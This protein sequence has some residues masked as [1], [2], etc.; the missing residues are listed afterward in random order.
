MTSSCNAFLNCDECWL[1]SAPVWLG[2]MS[3][4]SSD[5]VVDGSLLL[6]SRV[7]SNVVSSSCAVGV[8][9]VSVAS[10]LVLK[11]SQLRFRMLLARSC[12][13]PR[14]RLGSGR[15]VNDV[16]NILASA[17]CRMGGRRVSLVVL[18]PARL[19]SVRSALVLRLEKFDHNTF[20]A[21]GPVAFC[22]CLRHLK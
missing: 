14:L 6:R 1:V 7:D 8:A 21:M 10:A 20:V 9:G 11:R 2:C 18:G 4:T 13:K 3:L 16:A 19:A 15:P 12:V 17:L 5:A 22:M